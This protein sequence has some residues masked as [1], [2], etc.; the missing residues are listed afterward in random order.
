[1]DKANCGQAHFLEPI[2]QRWVS[3]PKGPMATKTQTFSW[4]EEIRLG[5]R[6]P[7]DNECECER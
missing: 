6:A 3:D 7:E 2:L 4:T 5:P 1:M